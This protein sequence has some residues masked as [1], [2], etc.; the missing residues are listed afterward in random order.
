MIQDSRTLLSQE[1]WPTWWTARDVDRHTHYASNALANGHEED[2]DL[3]HQPENWPRL[4]NRATCTCDKL[5]ENTLMDGVDP[6]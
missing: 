5:W 4:F 3:V 2:C 6:A 1:N